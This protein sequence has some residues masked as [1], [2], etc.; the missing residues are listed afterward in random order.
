MAP[1]LH[2]QGQECSLDRSILHGHTPAQR[3]GG[4]LRA[5]DSQSQGSGRDMFSRYSANHT[6]G[7]TKV[8]T[9][10][11]AEGEHP[12]RKM[13]KGL[14]RQLPKRRSTGQ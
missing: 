14:N 6:A 5:R 4:L 8:F 2:L 11:R 12:L 9:K 10:Q 1:F 3:E 13:A 7:M